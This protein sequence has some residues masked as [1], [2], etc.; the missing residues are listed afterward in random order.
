M[1]SVCQEIQGCPLVVYFDLFVLK[2]EVSRWIKGFSRSKEHHFSW[3]VKQATHKPHIG[4]G[5]ATV[6]RTI[7]GYNSQDAGKHW[8][9]YVELV[10]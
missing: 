3:L 6:L 1:A 5:Q 2:C 7:K 10:E 9:V 4:E 8:G